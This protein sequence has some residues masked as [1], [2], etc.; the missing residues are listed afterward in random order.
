MDFPNEAWIGWTLALIIGVPLAVTALAELHL[1]LQRAGNALAGPVN[2]LRIWL[3]PLAALLVLLT[4]AGGLDRDNNGVQIVA[5]LVG[6]I[7]VGVALS[8]LNAALFGN[9]RS[10]SWR[11]RLPSIFVDLGRL[12]LVVTGAAVVASL[13]WGLDV[14]GWFAALGVG[15]IVI[16]LSLQ[17][18]VGSVVSG[19]LLLFEQPFR[20]GDTLDV[21][22]VTGRV[23]EM[24]WRSTHVDTGTGIQIIPNATIAA[25]SFSNLTRPTP[26]HDL[27]VETAFAASDDPEEV[28]RCLLRT[29]VELPILRADGVPAVQALGGGMYATRL[30][31]ETAGDAP[32]AKSMLLTWAWYAAR[33]AGLTLDGVDAV[34]ATTEEVSKAVD[35]L[36]G[37]VP[38]S[39]GARDDLLAVAGLQTYGA[40]ETIVA[41]GVVP[42][43]LGVIVAGQVRLMVRQSDGA[44]LP[45]SDVG[46][47]DVV[48]ESVIN[49][50]PA[51]VAAQSLSVVH[52]LQVPPEALD[53]LM[54]SDREV[55]VRLNALMQSRTAEATQVLEAQRDTAPTPIGD[56]GGASGVRAS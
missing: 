5:T 33:R 37:L 35:V 9:A 50:D 39:T 52:V 51:I 23:V 30:P 1:R 55:S 20:I 40:G 18:A 49:R 34:A 56:T 3:L 36:A 32:D 46:P 7:A 17:N 42:A 54:L 11:D 47:G 53:R 12:F 6:T 48:A 31:L 44:M 41:A 38:V 25:A 14:G 26:A 29:A 22:G 43:G 13:V 27:I 45:L 2:R 4:Q 8:S 16:G 19:L 21:G 28:A 10:G 15:S 24:N